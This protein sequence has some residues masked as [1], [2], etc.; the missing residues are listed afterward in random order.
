MC[1]FCFDRN[2]CETKPPPSSSFLSGDGRKVILDRRRVLPS[3]GG[4]I[5]VGSAAAWLNQRRGGGGER[6]WDPLPR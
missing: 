1:F 2:M 3:M 6:V 4:C 5:P